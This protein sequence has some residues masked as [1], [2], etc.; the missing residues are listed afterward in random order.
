MLAGFDGRAREN[1]AIDLLVSAA[2]E[3]AMATARYVLPVP[4]GP[5]PNTMSLRSM[6][7]R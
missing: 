3:I 6:A 7:S 4:A 2:A 5:T 1:D